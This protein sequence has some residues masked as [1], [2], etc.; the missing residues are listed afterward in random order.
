MPYRIEVKP[1]AERALAKV[2]NPHRRR[3]AKAI[4]SLARD[5]RPGGCRKLTGAEDAYRIRVGDYRVAY[6]IADRVLIVHIVRVAH[7]KD[8]YRSR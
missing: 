5:P 7:R 1:R 4:D 6:Q 2:P 8:V 3:I